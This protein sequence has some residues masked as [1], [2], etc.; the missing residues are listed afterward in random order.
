MFEGTPAMKLSIMLSSN[1]ATEAQTL[2]NLLGKFRIPAGVPG[3][4]GLPTHKPPLSSSAM[5]KQQQ[6]LGAL[7]LSTQA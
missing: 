5:R 1:L 7:S 2:S 6:T 3:S 4:K